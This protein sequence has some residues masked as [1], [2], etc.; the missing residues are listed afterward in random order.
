MAKLTEEQKAERAAARQRRAAL[1]AEA[2]HDRRE[3]KRQE[4]ETTNACLTREE[5]EAGEPC[6]SCGLP[7]VDGLGS[8]P[9]ERDRTPEQQA[10]YEAAGTAYRE[11]HA[12]CR[13]H[14]WSMSG[15][16]AMHCGYCCPPHPLSQRQL[17]EFGR[18]FS[19]FK[20]RPAELDAWR[21]TLTCGHTVER[22]EHRSSDRWSGSLA[23]CPDCG[24]QRGIVTAMLL[25]PAASES[26]S[27][28]RRTLEDNRAKELTAAKRELTL[29]QREA[30]KLQKR[31]DALRHAAAL[32][33]PC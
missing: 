6:R 30:E 4:W 15:S 33:S 26:P 2:E 14:R 28:L 8:W 20:P 5:M 25:G 11:R 23:A 17:D 12:D 1:D 18:I 27:G 13:S 32:D 24:R 9:F 29:L 10:E 31:V 16:R 3:A 22:T 7:L 19:G 21:L